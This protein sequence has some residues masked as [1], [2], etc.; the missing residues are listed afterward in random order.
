MSG[1]RLKNRMIPRLVTLLS[2]AWVG[3][4]PLEGQDANYWTHQYGAR[5]TLLGGAVVGSVLDLSGTFYNPG[6]LGL[7]EKPDIFET[8]KVFHY[9]SVILK[10][11]GEEEHSFSTSSLGPAPSLV[12]GTLVS[13]GGGKNWIGFSFLTRHHISTG[14][15]GSFVTQQNVLPEPGLESIVSD[16]RLGINLSE[17]WAGLSWAYKV[18]QHIGIGISPYIV[19]RSHHA[20]NQTLAEALSTG[21]DISMLLQGGEF[22]YL[23]FRALC[24]IGAAFDFDRITLGLTLTTPSIK[25]Y[26]KGNIGINTT[27]VGLDLDGDGKK[28]DFLAADFQEELDANYKTPVSIGLGLTYKFDNVRLYGSAEW[29]AGMEK[30]DVIRGKDF[31]IQSTGEIIPIS[32]THELDSVINFGIGIEYIFNPKF[33]TY[34]SFTTDYSA[35]SPDTDTSLTA[36]TWN[37]YHMMAGSDFTLAGLSLTIGIGYAYGN[38][39][40]TQIPGRGSLERET[41]LEDFL[42]GLKYKYSSIKFLFGFAF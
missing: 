34:A 25:I 29:F 36:S 40:T 8:S 31:T 33:K 21:G 23:N 7:I 32:I 35:I 20:N 30:Y 26:G 22:R 14:L 17:S 41:F 10:G 37:I 11:Y 13:K 39:V 3:L 4:T 18:K 16:Y 38:K 1:L 12:A 19:V 24:K 2:I 42:S 28:E 9:P 15:A 27:V 5:A 6:G